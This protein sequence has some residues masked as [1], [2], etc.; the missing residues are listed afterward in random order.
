MCHSV[1][2]GCSFFI[3]LFISNSNNHCEKLGSLYL[4]TH[5]ES[6]SA[7][8]FMKYLLHQ[9]TMVTAKKLSVKFGGKSGQRCLIILLM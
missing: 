4:L 7:K 5:S 1:R 3:F 2:T 6:A 8:L 9:K